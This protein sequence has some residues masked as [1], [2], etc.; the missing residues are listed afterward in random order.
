MTFGQ[1]AQE[2]F[3][4]YVRPSNKYSEQ[5]AKQ[6]ILSANLLPFFGGM[7]LKAIGSNH[8]AQFVAK[9]KATGVSNKTINNKLTVLGKCLRCALARHTHARDP[10]AEMSTCYHG[11]SD[12]E[13]S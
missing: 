9:Q 11:L 3:D 12:P 8:I 10:I 2:W 6:K 7:A 1:F 4:T 5:Y 13:R